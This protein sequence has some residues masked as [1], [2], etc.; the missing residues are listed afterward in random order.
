MKLSEVAENVSHSISL[1]PLKGK[2]NVQI[3]D[4]QNHCTLY[5]VFIS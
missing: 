3:F 4:A 5:E 2:P 1:L